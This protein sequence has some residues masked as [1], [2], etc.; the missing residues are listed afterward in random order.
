MSQTIFGSG[1]TFQKEVGRR[2]RGSQIAT[3]RR[4]HH[5]ARERPE[6]GSEFKTR[7]SRGKSLQGLPWL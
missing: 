2:Q 7:R 6:E 3:Q 4:P 1:Q 5:E